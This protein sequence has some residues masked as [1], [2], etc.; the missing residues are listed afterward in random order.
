MLRPGKLFRKEVVILVPVLACAA[1]Y[2]GGAPRP[3]RFDNVD[4]FQHFA[5]RN[6]LLLHASGMAAGDNFYVSDHPVALEHLMSLTKKNC[7]QDS[8]WRGIIWVH[9]QSR[10]SHV[11]ARSIGGHCRIWGNLLVAGDEK[12]LDRVEDL[13]RADT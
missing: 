12:L 13:H 10:F 2:C 6:H 11:S 3:T 7:G 8:G 1:L 5:V 9:G 4:E